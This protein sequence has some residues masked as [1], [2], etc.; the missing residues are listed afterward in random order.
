MSTKKSLQQWY[1]MMCSVWFFCLTYELFPLA[2]DVKAERVIL[3]F[4]RAV[5]R[6][7]NINLPG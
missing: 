7:G 5:S 3:L 1:V 6:P 4:A 2:Q